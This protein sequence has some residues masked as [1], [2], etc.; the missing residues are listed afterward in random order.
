MGR[1]R[2]THAL[3]TVEIKVFRRWRIINIGL[4][5]YCRP[6]NKDW[7]FPNNINVIRYDIGK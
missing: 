6:G 1:F 3:D 2:V 5:K 7:L 4:R